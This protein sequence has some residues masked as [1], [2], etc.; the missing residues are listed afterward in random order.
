MAGLLVASSR[1][2]VAFAGPALSRYEVP[3]AD[4][5]RLSRR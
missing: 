5:R 1:G 3:A 4:G 2:P